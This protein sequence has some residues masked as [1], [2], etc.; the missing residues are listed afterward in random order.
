MTPKNKQCALLILSIIV[1]AGCSK[2]SVTIPKNPQFLMADQIIQNLERLHPSEHLGK[3]YHYEMLNDCNLRVTKSL[4]ENFVSQTTIDLSNA[5]FE[6]FGYASGLGYAVRVP[7]SIGGS[8]IFET[9]DP[10]REEAAIRQFEKLKSLC[11]S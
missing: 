11:R 9:P 4:S 8:T 5:S 10:E 6:V 3:S 7:D 2:E 1:N